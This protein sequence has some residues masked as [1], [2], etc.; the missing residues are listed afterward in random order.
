MILLSI[1]IPVYNEAESL[2]NLLGNIH[3]TVKTHGYTVEVIFINDGSTAWTLFHLANITRSLPG[4][5][6]GVMR[7]LSL[8]K[9]FGLSKT[10]VRSSLTL[11]VGIETALGSLIAASLLFSKHSQESAQTVLETISGHTLLF[12]LVG[13]VS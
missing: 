2:P 3:A 1:V 11:H 4:R 13:L 8:S 6:W 5:I 9:S 10:A 7:L 12:T